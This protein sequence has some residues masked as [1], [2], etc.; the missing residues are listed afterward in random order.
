M[1]ERKVFMRTRAGMATSVVAAILLIC[2]S[3]A[4]AEWTKDGKAICS[5][6]GD[7]GYGYITSDGAG[8]AFIAWDELRSDALG[9]DIYAQ[10]IDRD[11]NILWASDG[12]PI[13]TATGSQGDPVIIRDG[14]GGVI[15]AWRDARGQYYRVYAQ[16]VDGNGNIQWTPD[17]VSVCESIYPQYMPLI[18][19]DEIGNYFISWRDDRYGWGQ[20]CCQKLDGSGSLLWPAEG[21]R[22]CPTLGWQDEHRMIP[23]T[24]GGVILLWVDDRNSVR[25]PFIYAQRLDGNGNLLWGATGAPICLFGY[26]KTF[27]EC[28]PDGRGGGI[29]TWSDNGSGPDNVYAQ[30]FNSS[31]AILWKARG[32]PICEASGDQIA[33]HLT[34]DDADGAIIAWYDAREGRDDVYAQRVGSDGVS[35]WQTDGALVRKGPIASGLGWTIPDVVRDE[36]GGAIL[37][38][39]EGPG[40]PALWDVLAQRL[41][42]NGNLLWPDSAVAVCRAPGGQY[43]PQMTANG[44][45][46]AIVTWRDMRNGSLGAVYA[47]RVTASGETVA[48]LLQN[49]SVEVGSSSCITIEW[50]LSEVDADVQFTVLRSEDQSGTFEPLLAAEI[51]RN[52]LSF[53]FEDRTCRPGATYRYRVEISDKTGQEVLFESNPISIPPLPLALLQNYP[54]PFNPS[55]TIQYNTPEVAWVTLDV[56]DV[57]GRRIVRLINREQPAGVH[58]VRWNGSGMNGSAVSSGTYF[59]RLTANKKTITKKMIL[60]R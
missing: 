17:G 45:G 15:I 59:Y 51:Q 53:V 48:T 44:E 3:R 34:S 14:S 2:S 38:W 19:P 33:P 26:L 13:C 47:M 54:N 32:A 36:N 35:M 16:R 41:D 7:Q 42:G 49:F 52:G 37:T 12:V 39:Q 43:Y 8:G 46:G 5:S 60:L 25:Y 58:T 20:I 55:T 40:D 18:V 31:G 6:S 24:A 9:L 10:R 11:G 56:Y 30:R 28:I 4:Q 50:T 22:V 29:V 1:V 23:D 27:I 21:V 57:T